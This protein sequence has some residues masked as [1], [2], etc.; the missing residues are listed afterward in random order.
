MSR[1]IEE[2]I[3]MITINVATLSYA[4]AVNDINPINN[5]KKF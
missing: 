4:F 2:R 1:N 3:Y 5:S